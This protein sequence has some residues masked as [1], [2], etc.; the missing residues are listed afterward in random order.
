MGAL[1]QADR[2]ANER[3]GKSTTCE[4]FANRSDGFWLL[5]GIDQFMSGSFPAKFGHHGPRG[6]EGVYAHPC[7]TNDADGDL[8]WSFGPNGTRAFNALREWIAAPSR[9][10]CN[11]IFGHLMMTDPPVLQDCIWRLKVLPALYVSLKPPVEVLRQRAAARQMT[12]KMPTNILGEDAVKI[13]VDRLDRL[14]P[15]FTRAIYAETICDLEIDT[16][17]HAPEEVCELI[18]HRLAE[19]PGTAFE[20]LRQRYPRPET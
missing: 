17:Q 6:R 3:S 10:G 13:I 16:Q 20:T 7:G 11:I 9:A 12:K 8:R 4:M 15:W 14:R 18:E 1:P 19:K 2:F 5:F